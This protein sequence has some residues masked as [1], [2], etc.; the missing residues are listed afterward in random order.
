MK[1]NGIPATDIAVSPICLGTMTFG[2]PVGE[3]EAIRL[4]RHADSRGVNFIDTANMYEGYAR[5]AGSAGGVAEE[6]V[7]RAVRGCRSRFVIATKLGMKVGPAPEDEFTSPAAIEKQLE[8]SLKRL[9]TDYIDVYYLHKYDPGT[10]P[11]VIVQA[12]ARAIQSGK[13]RAWAVSNHT[14]AQLAALVSAADGLALSRPAMCQP[15]L[16]LIKPDALTDLLPL[17]AREKIAV[18]PYQILQGG[19]LTGK[20]RRGQAAPEGSR[21]AEKPDWLDE[22]DGALY[23]RLERIGETAAAMGLTMT[24]YA[25]RWALSQ[26]AVVSAIVGVKRAEQIDEAAAAVEGLKEGGRRWN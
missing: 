5:V 18:T 19:L 17:C 24:Q 10:A 25:I 2:T 11:E 12:M 21:R 16:S 4:V 7:G 23:A 22:P 3:A 13:I 26:P 15:A 9:G 8:R 20:Y 6:I 1:Y 14:A